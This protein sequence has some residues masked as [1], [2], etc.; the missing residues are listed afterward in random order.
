V[1]HRTGKQ[2]RG[3]GQVLLLQERCPRPLLSKEVLAV[4][5]RKKE[6][7]RLSARR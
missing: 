1:L 3:G 7:G 2:N 5:R 6:M 4:Q